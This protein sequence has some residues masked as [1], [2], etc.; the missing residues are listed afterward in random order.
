MM[1]LKV[2]LE[3]SGCDLISRYYADVCLE[4]PR[5]TM[6]TLSQDN[7]SLG[8]DLKPGSPEYEAGILTTCPRCS[9]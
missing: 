6:K 4:G 1:K 8:R 9:V 7:W 3:G 5:K 2:F